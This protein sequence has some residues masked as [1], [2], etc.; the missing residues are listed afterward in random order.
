MVESKLLVSYD[1]DVETS[2]TGCV[3]SEGVESFPDH[4]NVDPVEYD[5]KV[6]GSEEGK[7]N[8]EKSFR[9]DVDS[10]VLDLD[11][12]IGAFVI[13]KVIGSD[14]KFVSA[15]AVASE[16]AGVLS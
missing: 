15:V 13:E 6:T 16:I 10:P 9:R 11:E 8:V 1:S 7:V 5:P 2:F 14:C 12:N 4:F 3:V